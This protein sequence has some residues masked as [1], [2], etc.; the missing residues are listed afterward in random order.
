[1][2][3]SICAGRGRRARGDQEKEIALGGLTHLTRPDRLAQKR[4]TVEEEGIRKRLPPPSLL[5]APNAGHT[6]AHS[7][8]FQ[9]LLVRG[10]EKTS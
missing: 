10:G 5:Q 3:W 4:E 8:A 1:M 6:Q 7:C 9:D 2:N